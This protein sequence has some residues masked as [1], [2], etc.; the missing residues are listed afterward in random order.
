MQVVVLGWN[1]KLCVG[2]LKPRRTEEAP[3][4]VMVCSIAGCSGE[5]RP[6]SG[7]LDKKNSFFYSKE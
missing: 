1:R 3:N 7:A 2:Y 4:K 6:T 5:V